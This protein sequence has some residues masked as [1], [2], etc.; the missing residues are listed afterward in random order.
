L[1]IDHPATVLKPA[2][3]GADIGRV[4][5]A[6]RSTVIRGSVAFGE[7]GA[8]WW[9]VKHPEH[10]SRCS[11]HRPGPLAIQHCMSNAIGAVATHWAAVLGVGFCLGATIGIVLALLVGLPRRV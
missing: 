11:T 9:G 10:V 3:A 4:R 6:I 8:I 1:T 2:T 7:L 5:G